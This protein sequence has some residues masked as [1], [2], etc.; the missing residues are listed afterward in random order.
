MPES[1]SWES[2]LWGWA[3]PI[4]RPKPNIF[5]RPFKKSTRK[6]EG[7]PIPGTLEALSQATHARGLWSLR[8][9]WGLDRLYR[10]VAVGALAVASAGSEMLPLAE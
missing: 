6:L 10:D 3:K 8:W 1:P 2:P 7:A 5:K 4:W 9:C